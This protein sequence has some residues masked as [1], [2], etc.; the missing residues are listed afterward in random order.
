[1]NT[2]VKIIVFPE[3]AP[4]KGALETAA[5]DLITC[6]PL[7]EVVYFRTDEIP[8]ALEDVHTR[9]SNLR[10][11]SFNKVSFPAAFPGLRLIGDGK[12]FPSL[13]HVLLSH[14]TVYRKDWNP[15][16]TLLACRMSSGNRLNTLAIVGSLGS[17]ERV[18]V[19][20]IRDMVREISL[21]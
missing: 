1:M 11:L 5:L 4:P 7:E 2:S 16:K 15:L 3:A 20:G 8:I 9:L 13:E 18:V 12:V 21:S 17:R 19:E 14:V 10:A 6:A